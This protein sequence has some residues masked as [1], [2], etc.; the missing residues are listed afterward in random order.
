MRPEA[1]RNPSRVRPHDPTAQDHDF[2]GE[3]ARHA[4]EQHAAATLVLLQV[5]CA[6]LDGHAPGHLGHRG[7][8]RQLS[9]RQLDG[10]VGDRYALLLENG[11]SQLLI[12]GE[13]K[14]CEHDLVLADAVVLRID[15]LLD[16]HDHLGSSP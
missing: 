7:K 8:E 10:F 13:M 14:I 12:G 15:R 6:L 11:P 3:H 5:L 2:R 9:R 16:L 1:G 4:S